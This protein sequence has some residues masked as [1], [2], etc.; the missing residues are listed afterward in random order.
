MILR[1]ILPVIKIDLNYL[2]LSFKQYIKAIENIRFQ[3]YLPS[4]Y[5]QTYRFFSS[6]AEVIC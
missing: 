1:S 5:N 6:Y 3:T 2:E 4:I